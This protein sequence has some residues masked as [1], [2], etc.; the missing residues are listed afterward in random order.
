[1][2]DINPAL[3]QKILDVAKEQRV[4]HVH[5]HRQADYLWR[6]VEIAEPI[7]HSLNY[8]TQAHSGSCSDSALRAINFPVCGPSASRG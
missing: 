2:T 5:H 1:V 4:F 7:F 3:G 6:T 8:I